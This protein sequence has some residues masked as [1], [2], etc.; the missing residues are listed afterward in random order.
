MKDLLLYS[1]L[2]DVTFLLQQLLDIFFSRIKLQQTTLD[3]F[4]RHQSPS[5]TA[6]IDFV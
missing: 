2:E 6:N 3:L 1:S 4:V 5:G